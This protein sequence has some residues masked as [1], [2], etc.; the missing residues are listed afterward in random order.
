M[1]LKKEKKQKQKQKQKK[2]I[3]SLFLMHNILLFLSK[4]TVINIYIYIYISNVCVY[5][6]IIKYVGRNFME[7]ELEELEC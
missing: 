2:P 4:H 1:T 5:I 7:W 3:I 6:Y